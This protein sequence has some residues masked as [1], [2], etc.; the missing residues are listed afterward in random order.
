MSDSRWQPGIQE[1]SEEWFELLAWVKASERRRD[2]LTTM[3]EGSKNTSDFAKRW[4]VEPDTVRYH[5][6]Q[7]RTG[8]THDDYPSLIEVLTPGRT[9]YKLYGLTS[10]GERIVDSL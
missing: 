6:N 10:E 1:G 4:D 8:G 2:I 5:F 9:R 3:S 7:L